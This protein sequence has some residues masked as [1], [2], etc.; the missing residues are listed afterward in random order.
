[1]FALLEILE[2][3]GD[4]LERPAKVIPWP[5][6]KRPRSEDQGQFLSVL[7]CRKLY[8]WRQAVANPGESVVRL[9]RLT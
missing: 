2:R 5:D 3:F 7:I 4:P 6:K 9:R 8:A 1:V